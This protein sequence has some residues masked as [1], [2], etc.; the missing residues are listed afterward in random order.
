MATLTEAERDWLMDRWQGSEVRVTDEGGVEVLSHKEP[1]DGETE[2]PWWVFAG[3]LADL[4]LEYLHHT[5]LIPDDIRSW[6]ERMGWTQG[7]AA[8]ALGLSDRVTV[9]RWETGTRTPPSYLR[10]AME[11]IE[12]GRPEPG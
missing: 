7:E 4:Q 5:P 10:L 12:E 2:G 8:R 1:A 3:W 6:R 11:R 9:A